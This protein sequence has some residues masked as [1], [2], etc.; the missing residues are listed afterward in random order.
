MRRIRFQMDRPL[1][2]LTLLLLGV[3]LVMVFSASANMSEERFG[4]AYLF[5]RKEILWDIMALSALFLCARLDYHRWQKLSLAL[6]LLAFAISDNRRKI[7]P[8]TICAALA[9]QI[10]IGALIETE[11][12][13]PLGI[14]TQPILK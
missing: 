7:R 2:I 1:L 14:E 4:S 3:G 8:R 5:V 9:T 6:L 11:Q 12:S 13:R 10:G